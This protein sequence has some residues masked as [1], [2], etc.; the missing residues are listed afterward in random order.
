MIDYHPCGDCAYYGDC[1]MDYCEC[2]YADTKDIKEE[3]CK[4][5]AN[6]QY[7]EKIKEM[8]KCLK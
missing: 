5:C 3:Y 6:Y 1:K 4:F 2:E 7:C 8:I